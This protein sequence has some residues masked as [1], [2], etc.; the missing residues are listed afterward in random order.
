M[1]T[2]EHIVGREVLDSRGNPTVEVEVVL[3]SRRPRPGRSCPSGASTGA[4]RG[5][6]AARRRRPLRRQGRADG[7]RPRQRRD[8]RRAS[9]GSTPSTSAAVDRLL[10]DLDGT[11]NKGRLGANAILGV[12]LAVGQGRGRRARAAAVPLRRRRQR[13]RAAGADDERAQRRRA[14]RQ[15]RRLPGVHDHA[16]RR[17]VASPRRCA[18]APRPTTR[19]R[20]VLHDRGLVHRG[21]R[22]GRLRARTSASN[23]EA[24]QLLRRGDREGRLHA[25]RRDRASRSTPAVHRVLR[26]R[27]LRAS[28]ARAAR[29]RADRD[30]R[31]LGRPRATATRSCRS[32]TAWPRR[33]G[34]AGRRS[35]SALGDRVQLVGDDLFV[36]NVERLRAGHRRAAS[37]TRSSSRSTRSARSPRRSRPSSLATRSALHRGDVAPLG[38]DRGHHHRRP[39]RRHQLRPDQDRRARPAAT[40]SPSTTSCCASRRTSARPPRSRVPPRWLEGAVSPP[41]ARPSSPDG[42]GAGSGRAPKRPATQRAAE[43]GA[44]EEAPGA[45]GDAPARRARRVGARGRVP[46]GAVFPTRTLLTQR[47][48]HRQGASRS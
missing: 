1:S 23:E 41:A 34:T 29:S 22:R 46:A 12:S 37:P 13:P 2:I 25:R 42:A 4:V 9:S 36:T 16:G 47:V 31:L 48:R 18:G 39:R 21:R 40:G 33:T 3:D 6:R 11:D 5:G 32:R 14:R 38:R 30:G 24:V 10:L 27:R 43:Q 35:P 7:G 20:R 28:P 44:G 15:Q 45:H 19:S 8:R 26:R 17:G